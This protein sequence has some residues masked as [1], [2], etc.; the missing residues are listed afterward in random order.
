GWKSGDTFLERNETD[1]RAIQ[2]TNGVW[3]SAYTTMHR[4]R[5]FARDAATALAA[6]LPSQ[7]GEQGEMWFVMGET[8][9]QISQI[10][11]N[12]TP[13][14]IVKGAVAQYSAGGT[15]QSG[16]QLAISDLYS[17]IW[18]SGG[19][20]AVAPRVKQAALIAKAEALVDLGQFAQAA[21]L[22]PVSAVPTSYSYAVT[23]S[24]PTVSNEIWSLNA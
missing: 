21:A 17:A 5:G 14:S 10:F 23:F 1:Q 20:D 13:F 12:G 11:C 3:A 24:Q 6:S 8:E 7:P 15:N 9:L 2:A 18:L 4:A 16:F 22:V 19:T